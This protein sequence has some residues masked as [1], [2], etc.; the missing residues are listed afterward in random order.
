MNTSEQH[1]TPE[2]DLARKFAQGTTVRDLADQT[3]RSQKVIRDLLWAAGVQI[4]PRSAPKRSP[5]RKPS[6][7]SSHPLVNK[8][9]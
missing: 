9:F 3:G 7:P 5:R 2:A 4:P 8:I 1:A 6:K